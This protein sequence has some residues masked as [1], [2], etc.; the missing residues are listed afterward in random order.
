[1]VTEPLSNRQFV[2]HEYLLFWYILMSVALR[3][4][5]NEQSLVCFAWSNFALRSNNIRKEMCANWNA[6]IELQSNKLLYSR[7]ISLSLWHCASVSSIPSQSIGLA[8]GCAL[9]WCW[10]SLCDCY[11]FL[12]RILSHHDFYHGNC[13]YY[14]DFYGHLFFIL[15]YTFRFSVT[16]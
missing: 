15:S 12:D 3:T 6:D 13:D 5:L 16:K 14:W 2:I 10:V 4:K 8:F 7:Y 11:Y 1:M 9:F